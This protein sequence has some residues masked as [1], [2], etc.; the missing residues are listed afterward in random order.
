MTLYIIFPSR[1]YHNFN[2]GKAFRWLTILYWSYNAPTRNC[3]GGIYCIILNWNNL[4]WPLGLN[5]VNPKRVT[6]SFVPSLFLAALIPSRYFDLLYISVISLLSLG[7]SFWEYLDDNFTQILPSFSC[8]TWALSRSF[9]TL[10]IFVISQRYS[11]QALHKF[12]LLC[13]SSYV[14]LLHTY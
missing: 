5:T 10:E 7:R 3:F 6:S 1:N 14:L 4:P 12:W 8:N 11:C 13:L 9:S 2:G